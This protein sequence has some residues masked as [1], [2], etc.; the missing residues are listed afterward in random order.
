[1]GECAYQS[2]WRFGDKDNSMVK[3]KF[4]LFVRILLVYIFEIFFFCLYLSFHVYD[5]T[6]NSNCVCD[7]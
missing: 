7:C 6:G 2:I 3:W 5:L 4:K 1:M